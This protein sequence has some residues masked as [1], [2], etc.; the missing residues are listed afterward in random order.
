MVSEIL[1]K[2][3][4]TRHKLHISS[5]PLLAYMIT[6]FLCL[7]ILNKISNIPRGKNIRNLQVLF[8]LELY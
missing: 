6:C 1:P 2:C 3:V 7:E 8:V 4:R 5:K